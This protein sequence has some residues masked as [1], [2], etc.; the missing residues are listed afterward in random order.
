MEKRQRH[1]GII[2]AGIVVLIGAMVLWPYETS[3]GNISISENQMKISY[4]EAERSYSTR[5]KLSQEKKLEVNGFAKEGKVYLRVKQGLF[6][7]IYD[8]SDF[9]GEID[10]E[11]VT[12]GYVNVEVLMKKQEELRW[13][14][15]R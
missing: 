3:L 13:R 9:K 7:E 15:G 14:F 6:E 1:K 12:E 10:L 5:M 8:I 2:A 4:R 11:D